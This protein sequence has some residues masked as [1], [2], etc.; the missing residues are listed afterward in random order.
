MAGITLAV[1][2]L[3]F[4]GVRFPWGSAQ[5]LAPLVIGMALI[6][7]FIMYEAK[8]PREPTIPWEVL[9]NRTTVSG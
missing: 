5:T 3:T 8:V 1:T 4:A 6:F 2:G 7:G 9:N